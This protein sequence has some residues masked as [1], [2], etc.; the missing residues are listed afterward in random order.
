MDRQRPSW[1]VLVPVGAL[2]LVLGPFL[3]PGLSRFAMSLRDE[4]EPRAVAA[5]EVPFRPEEHIA[6]DL[7]EATAP[8]VVCVSNG[9]R[10]PGGET[11]WDTGSGFVWDR[12][13]HVVTNY[14]V[15]HDA[16]ELT[17]RLADLTNWDATLVGY[18][19]D[20]DLA[21]LKIGAPSDALQPIPLGSSNELRVGQSTYSIGNPFGLSSTLSQGIVSALGRAIRSGTG[22]GRVI[23]DVIQTDAPINPG[24][25][26]GPL[27]DSAG[28]LIGVTT[29]ILGGT[30]AG[31][32]F[33][34]PVDTVNRIVPD[35]IR[36]GRATRAGLGVRVHTSEFRGK[37]DG[38]VIASVVPGSVA[39]K[40]GLEGTYNPKTQQ[41]QP[42]KSGDV[43]TG[44]D[45]HS[46]HTFDDL[47]RALDT[48]VPGDV[49]TLH[50]LRR[51]QRLEIPIEL[52]L[53]PDET[54]WPD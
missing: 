15:V 22:E 12:F 35:L 2:G 1:S 18:D 28:R 7:F 33:A 42:E 3:L 37:V 51:G 46:I 36:Y 43:I 13:G 50:V 14:H 45:S 17:V 19:E 32:G 6:I 26:G 38:V 21:V 48:H 30:G 11:V 44:I 5:R 49:V 40:A 29:A 25:S 53:L 10:M 31:I 41:F 47:Y 4:G 39:A 54:G 23:Q 8:S 52:Q 27:L 34:V 9:R 20:K 24:N 16:S